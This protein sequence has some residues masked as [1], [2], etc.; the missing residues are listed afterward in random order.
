[1]TCDFTYVEPVGKVSA[2]AFDKVTKRL[3]VTGIDLPTKVKPA[4]ED[5]AGPA[6]AT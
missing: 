3:T 2:A 1:M 5:L 6:A 4:V